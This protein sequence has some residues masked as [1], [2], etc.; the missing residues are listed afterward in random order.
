MKQPRY[1]KKV[2][3]ENCIRSFIIKSIHAIVQ[4]RNGVVYNT[5]C[6]S[7]VGARNNL[8]V[9]IEEDPEIGATIKQ[10]L[11]AAF[12]VHVHDILSLEISTAWPNNGRMV[13]EVWQFHL[14][15]ADRL[16]TPTNSDPSLQSS[17]TV[18]QS[19]PDGDGA[20]QSEEIPVEDLRQS[21]LF[22]KL[23][24][25]L[26]A[27]IVATRLLPAYRLSRNQDPAKYQMCYTLRRGST[28][29]SRLG[30]DVRTQQI[31]RLFSG[32]AMRSPPKSPATPTPRIPGT[33]AVTTENTDDPDN[34]ERVFLS[35][36]VYYRPTFPPRPS[37]PAKQLSHTVTKGEGPPGLHN[38]H[39]HA[40]VG[41][42]FTGTD[43]RLVT[44]APLSHPPRVRPAFAEDGPEDPADE[45]GYPSHLF[46]DPD[47]DGP[48]AHDFMD[49]SWPDVEDDEEDDPLDH[50][51]N[52]L[53]GNSDA[54]EDT[55]MSET[56]YPKDPPK[57]EELNGEDDCNATTPEDETRNVPLQLPFSTVGVSGEHWTQLFVELRQRTNLDLFKVPSSGNTPVTGGNTQAQSSLFDAD[58][59]TEELERHEKILKEFDEFLAKFCS[60]DFPQPLTTG[61]ANRLSKELA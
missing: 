42:Y 18:E 19:R 60:I 3:I 13:V 59:L 6:I 25:L 58:A 56:M 54:G 20:Q 12:P 41:G 35:C 5:N 52:E 30:P 7:A 49:P 22:E 23:G 33:Q 55:D 38:N 32:L 48:H 27:I 1:E 61:N 47:Y 44:C 57:G 45:R 39:R 26:K 9:N 43:G 2:A 14:D 36:T 50:H 24:T 31:G 28:N 53:D 51:S 8:M 4:A 21:R 16:T 34:L 40:R 10:T 11:D 46:F 17:P 15:T 29:L 37:L